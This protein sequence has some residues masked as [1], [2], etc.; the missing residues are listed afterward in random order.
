MAD[1]EAKDSHGRSPFLY[2]CMGN[3]TQI[4]TLLVRNIEFTCMLDPK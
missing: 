4:I 3:S 2:A 1:L